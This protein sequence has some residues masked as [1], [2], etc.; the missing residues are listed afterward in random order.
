MTDSTMPAVH[1]LGQVE[2]F[3]SRPIDRRERAFSDFDKSVDALLYLLARP[4]RRLI[5]LDELRRAIEALPA[6]TYHGRSYYENW[7]VAIRDLM[8]EKG[9]V[10]T[11]ELDALVDAIAREEL[12]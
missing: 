7:L 6:E 11:A 3:A 1:D 2:P 9:V 10:T 12:A 5:R 8:V 4:E